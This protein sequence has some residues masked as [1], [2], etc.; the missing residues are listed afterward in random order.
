MKSA[1]AI[2]S[3]CGSLEAIPADAKD[4]PVKI[5]NAERLAASLREHQAEARLY[6][7]LTTLRTDVPL[8]PRTVGELRPGGETN[9]SLQTLKG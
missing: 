2:L 6:K 7:T 4:W 8:E 5:R 3:T 9:G 1:S